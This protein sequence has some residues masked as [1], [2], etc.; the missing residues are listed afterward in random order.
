MNETKYGWRCTDPDCAQYMQRDGDWFEMIQIVSPNDD[1][2]FFVLKTVKWL[3]DYTEEEQADMTGAYG[4][5]LD[6]LYRDFGKEKTEDLVMEC[7]L[8]LS[9]INERYIIGETNTFEEAEQFIKELVEKEGVE[10]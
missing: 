6:G 5:T 1:N 7:I 4:Y 10:E 2:T 8:E 3:S 9:I